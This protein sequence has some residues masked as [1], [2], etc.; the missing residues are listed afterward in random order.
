[1]SGQCDEHS[2]MCGDMGAINANITNLT[3]AITTLSAQIAAISAPIHSRINFVES[4]VDKHEDE[5]QKYREKIIITEKVLQ[6]YMKHQDDKE[7][8]AMWRIGI[9]VTIITALVQ[10]GMKIWLG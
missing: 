10:V 3:A 2:K 6:D 9:T 8:T 5:S 4:K 7:K 1:M